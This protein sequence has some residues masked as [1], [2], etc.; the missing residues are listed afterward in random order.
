MLKLYGHSF[1]LASASLGQ[2]MVVVP[3]QKPVDAAAPQFPASL[4]KSLLYMTPR[5]MAGSTGY[6]D[7]LDMC[8]RMLQPHPA[9]RPTATAILAWHCCFNPDSPRA[10]LANMLGGLEAVSKEMWL[11][12]E[13]RRWAAAQDRAIKRELQRRALAA[14]AAAVATPASTTAAAPAGAGSAPASA[15]A[16]TT[17]AGAQPSAATATAG[18]LKQH[19][20]AA[21]QAAKHAEA[22]S[23]SDDSDS[24]TTDGEGE[25]LDIDDAATAPSNSGATGAIGEDDLLMAGPPVAA[26]AADKDATDQ[27][28][29][30]GSRGSSKSSEMSAN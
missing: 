24:S 11:P 9:D 13:T 8:L 7:V 10:S 17:R 25:D 20:Q 23:S 1:Q 22:D 3:K 4:I 29:E 16:S 26:E 14:G 21:Q 19:R 5:D 15:S 28:S 27:G 18:S 2:Y 6:A 30:R 12:P